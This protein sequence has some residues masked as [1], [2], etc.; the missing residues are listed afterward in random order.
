M[1]H[2]NFEPPARKS[3]PPPSPRERALGL[4]S[5]FSRP[6]GDWI[7][8]LERNGKPRNSFERERLEATLFVM[9]EYRPRIVKLLGDV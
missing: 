1:T 8:M 6:A 2:P 5:A 9:D 4:T 7:A 3:V